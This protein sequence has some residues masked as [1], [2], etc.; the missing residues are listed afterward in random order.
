VR[1]MTP[2]PPPHP[3]HHHPRRRPGVVEGAARPNLLVATH[4]Q[5]SVE[6]TLALLGEVRLAGP[7]RIV[8]PGPAS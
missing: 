3:H 4:N 1:G 6:K 2:P 8:R 7:A 5:H